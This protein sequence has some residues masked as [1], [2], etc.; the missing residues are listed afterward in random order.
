MRERLVSALRTGALVARSDHRRTRQ[1]F[2]LSAAAAAASLLVAL[3]ALG[4]TSGSWSRATLP[5]WRTPVLAAEGTTWTTLS[6]SQADGQVMTVA[7]FAEEPGSPVPPPAGVDHLPAPGQVIASPALV[8]LASRLDPDELADR[9]PGTP[10]TW[11]VLGDAALT[12][13][14]EL[15]AFV[16]VAPGDPSLA[17][18]LVF[19]GSGPGSETISGAVS[20]FEPVPAGD[21]ASDTSR[22]LAALGC[23]LLLVPV[24]VLAAAGGRLAGTRRELVLARLRLAGASPRQVTAITVAE[25]AAAGTAGALVGTAAYLALLPVLARLPWQGHPWF[26]RDLVPPPALVV[27]AAAAVVVV[28]VSAALSTL[29]AVITSPLGAAQLQ[30]A[31]STTAGRLVLAVVA[32]AGVLV[33]LRSSGA[34]AVQLLAVV[35]VIGALNLVGPFV[36]DRLG[37]VLASLSRGPAGLLAGRALSGDPRG[38]WRVISGIVLAGFAAGFFS[39]AAIGSASENPG[40]VLLAA[41]TS[42]VQ[43]VVGQVQT[44]LGETTTVEVLTDPTDSGVIVED[45]VSVVEATVPDGPAAVDRAVT[46]LDGLVPGQRPIVLAAPDAELGQFFDS[47]RTLMLGVLGLSFA[48]ALVSTALT[49]VASLAERREEHRSM[50]TMGASLRVV[51][52]ART[53][54]TIVPLV[55]LSVLNT[56]AGAV[57]AW[58]VNDALGTTS[59]SHAPLVLALFVGVGTLLMLVVI[60]L[61]GRNLSRTSLPGQPAADG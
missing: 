11:G 44:A 36:V 12:T 39:M 28:L 41:P 31:R 16:G 46:A 61:T 18:P 30:E 15:V 37:R 47:M 52:R 40:A 14:D 43:T 13:P 22:T 17:A 9:F 50:R 38:T 42:T 56:L 57:V 5:E 26:V 58:K 24:L 45:G 34:L 2:V 7:R 32:V 48:L 55:V 35:V 49:S 4:V 19:G 59:Q 27:A 54:Q 23:A 1:T 8:E 25:T 33:A 3:V 6:T 51:E 53:L 20:G 21:L 60:R 10:T 29:R